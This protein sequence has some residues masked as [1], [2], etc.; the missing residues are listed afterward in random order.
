MKKEEVNKLIKEFAKN[1]LF[2]P[3]IIDFTETS[4]KEFY[5][6]FSLDFERYYDQD[7]DLELIK[8]HRG[9]LAT[10]FYRLSSQLYLKNNEEQALE[11]SSLSFYLTGIELYY[12]A[13]IGTGLK[14]NHGVGT[15][16]GARS[17]VGNNVLLHHNVT[18]GEKMGRP[19][20]KDNVIIFPGA[21]IV[22]P[23]VISENS[24]IGANVFIDRNINAN[25][26]IK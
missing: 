1:S 8:Y 19:E 5:K 11:L 2:N 13:Q 22:G 3:R 14:I 10:F 26:I 17:I 16:V 23:I 20:I 15:V 7:I 24:I 25:S 6:I 4:F 21:V 18:L 9:L 12:S